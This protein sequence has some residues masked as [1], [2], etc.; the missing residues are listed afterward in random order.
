LQFPLTEELR[1]EADEFGLRSACP[2]CFYYAAG[3]GRCAHEWPNDEQKRWPL[4]AGGVEVAD[5]CKEFELL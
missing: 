3:D 2:H 4:G 1:R 5:F